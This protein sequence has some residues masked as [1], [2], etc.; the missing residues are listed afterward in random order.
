MKVRAQVQ[1]QMTVLI[2]V[3][4]WAAESSFAD[5]HKQAVREATQTL[6]NTL[7]TKGV[8]VK[9]SPKIM[10]VVTIEDHDAR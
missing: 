2:D 1:M 5:L 6:E 8:I 10:R 4:C 7:K 9:D 3:G